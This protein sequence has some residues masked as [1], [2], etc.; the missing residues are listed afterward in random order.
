MKLVKTNSLEALDWKWYSGLSSVGVVLCKN[1]A[2]QTAC[3]MG[4]ASSGNEELDVEHIMDFGA[5]VEK[6]VAEAMFKRTLE[7]YKW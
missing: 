2:G 7:N 4:V 3:Y 6:P 1:T 5:K